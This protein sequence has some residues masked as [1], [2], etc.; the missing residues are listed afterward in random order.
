[1]RLRVYICNEIRKLA[2]AEGVHDQSENADI[3]ESY[4][5]EQNAVGAILEISEALEAKDKSRPLHVLIDEYDYPV[6][7]AINPFKDDKYTECMDFYRH[8]FAATKSVKGAIIVTGV[9]R[10]GMAGV[11]SGANHLDDVTFS[12][13]LNGLLGLS[14]AEVTTKYGKA[15]PLVAKRNKLKRIK[16]LKK[17]DDILVRRISLRSF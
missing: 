1:M 11:F 4:V 8:F 6:I 7:R 3:L 10:I 2:R 15:L 13:D 17:K 5:A 9:S 12:H 16:E 14:W